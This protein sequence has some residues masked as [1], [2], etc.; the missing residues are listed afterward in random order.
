MSD[1]DEPEFLQELRGHL[2]Q[3]E[4]PVFCGGSPVSGGGDPPQR[5]DTFLAGTTAATNAGGIHV[6]ANSKMRKQV[7]RIRGHSGRDHESSRA[8]AA[9]RTGATFSIWVRHDFYRFEDR[10]RIHHKHS[11]C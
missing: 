7:V 2:G 1:L 10:V 9:A 5:G 4:W 6:V 11:R 8:V 3:R